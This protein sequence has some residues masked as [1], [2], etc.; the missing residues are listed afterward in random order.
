ML[1]KIQKHCEYC[2]R[3]GAK[4]QRFKFPL[5]EESISFNHSIYCEILTLERE[6]VLH[7]VDEGIRFQQAQRL[8]NM[9][10]PELWREIKQCWINVYLGPP[11]IITH[12]A[13]SNFIA[14]A[15]QQNADLMHINCKEVPIEVANR[16]QFVERYHELLCRAFSIIRTECTICLSTTPYWEPSRASTIVQAPTD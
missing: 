3:F 13:G 4:Q 8:S 5:R 9:S 6:H 14:R 10:A 16:M 2:Q 11:D 7:I 12:D 15:F 1:R